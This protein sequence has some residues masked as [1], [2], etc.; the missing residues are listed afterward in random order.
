VASRWKGGLAAAFV[1]LVACALVTL[2]LTDEG[3]AAGGMVT[4]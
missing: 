2:D 3:C 4:P 1:A